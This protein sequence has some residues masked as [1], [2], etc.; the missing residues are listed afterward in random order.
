[1]SLSEHQLSFQLKMY[2]LIQK[3]ELDNALEFQ[4]VKKWLNA[5][6]RSILDESDAILQPKYQLI[7]TVGNQLALDGGV[8]RWF[9]MQAVLKRVPH[10]MQ[11]LFKEY[12]ND[13]IEFNEKYLKRYRPDVF[14]PCRIIKESIYLQLKQAI[15]TDLFADRM[16]ITLPEMKDSTRKNVEAFLKQQS[17]E[18]FEKICKDLTLDVQNIILILN[19]LLQFD[20]LKLMLVKRWRVNYGINEKGKD[21]RKMAVPFR[22]KDVAA[23]L[24]EFGHP[25]V[26]I[27]FT[28]LSY[29]YSGLCC[30]AKHCYR[31]IA[32]PLYE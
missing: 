29:Y 26:A 5:N 22:A 10:H 31:N 24:T 15:I 16:D 11:Q 12:G 23:E 32:Y 6:I 8:Q 18:P 17:R 9:V 1:M 2:E 27:G 4:T 25:D 30:V 20:V 14:I 3:N 21:K 13:A 7:Y 28:H 19:G